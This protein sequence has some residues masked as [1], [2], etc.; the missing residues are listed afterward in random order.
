MGG[1]KGSKVVLFH[2]KL[3]LTS[4]DGINLSR[5]E[6]SE[7]A[8]SC[9]WTETW[10]QLHQ[11]GWEKDSNELWT[12]STKWKALWFPLIKSPFDFNGK[13]KHTFIS[14]LM[15]LCGLTLIESF[16]SALASCRDVCRTHTMMTVVALAWLT[17]PSWPTIVMTI[18]SATH[19]N[20]YVWPRNH[21][22]LNLS[23]CSVEIWLLSHLGQTE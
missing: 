18:F 7:A 11:Q 5:L 3:N 12:V 16:P 13:L 8:S 23:P 19:R 15:N 6:K 20:E 21:E 14:L 4:G 1:G 10:M 2:I 9:S 17:D 22:N